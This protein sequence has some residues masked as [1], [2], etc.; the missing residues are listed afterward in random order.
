MIKKVC[1]YCNFKSLNRAAMVV[2]I[3]S[4][5]CFLY[6]NNDHKIIL[7]TEDGVVI[8]DKPVNNCFMCGRRLNLNATQNLY[9]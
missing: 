3:G 8:T 5:V 9:S 4:H 6:I 7:K 1:P 2:H